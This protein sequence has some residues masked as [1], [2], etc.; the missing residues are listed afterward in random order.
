M[1]HELLEDGI[2]H[3]A[4]ITACESCF[5]HVLGMADTCDEHLGFELIVA[6]DP[7]DLANKC[8]AIGA[9][10]VQSTDERGDTPCPGLCGQQG[11]CGRKTEGDV[12]A[13][14][15]GSQPFG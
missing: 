9:D 11:L 3:C 4:N 6:V 2:G 10:I 7:H 15:L 8:H 1:L 13:D 5:D 14:S 12:H